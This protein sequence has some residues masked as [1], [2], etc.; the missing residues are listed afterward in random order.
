MIPA[1]AYEHGMQ[2]VFPPVRRRLVMAD[3]ASAQGEMRRVD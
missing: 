2:P 3:L 1:C